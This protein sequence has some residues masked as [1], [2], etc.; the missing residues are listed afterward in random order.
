MEQQ[1]GYIVLKINPEASCYKAIRVGLP[2]LSIEMNVKRDDHAVSFL[3]TFKPY[4]IMR[5]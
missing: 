3:F 2:I 1:V 5:P 4:L